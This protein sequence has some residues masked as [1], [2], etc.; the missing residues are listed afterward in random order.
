MA[1]RIIS[2]GGWVGGTSDYRSAS[3]LLVEAQGYVVETFP[4]ISVSGSA[5]GT[6]NA[7]FYTLIGLREGMFISRINWITSVVASSVTTI[8][9]GIWQASNLSL[10]ASTAN[11]T[12]ACV[13]T[14][15]S[16]IN[17]STA[18]TVPS[19]GAYYVGLLVD[20]TTP[21]QLSKAPGTGI[22]GMQEKPTGSSGYRYAGYQT[23]Q[24]S[25]PATASLTTT[26]NACWFGLS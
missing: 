19:S 22:N 14:G 24:S 9:A 18:Y 6:D 3:D 20:A 4:R 13:A 5:H 8:Q 11:D 21:A 1:G 12:A 23:G 2:S 17:L 15:L 10:V 25:L 16:G 7:I 26:A